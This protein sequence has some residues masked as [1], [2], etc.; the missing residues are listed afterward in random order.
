MKPLNDML[1]LFPILVFLLVILFIALYYYK[2]EFTSRYKP[3]PSTR[4]NDI[5][6]WLDRV[7]VF[8]DKYE[9]DTGELLEFCWWCSHCVGDHCTR[10]GLYPVME[11]LCDDFYPKNPDEFGMENY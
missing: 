5:D 1:M 9:D 10:H 4:G 2:D 3:P 7:C 11:N 6:R 8:Q